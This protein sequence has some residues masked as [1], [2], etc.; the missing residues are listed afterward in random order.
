[1]ATTFLDKLI[2]PEK[3]K[4]IWAIAPSSKFLAEEMVTERDIFWAEVIVEFWAGDGVFTQRIF[5]LAERFASKNVK[6]FIIELDPELY[7]KLIQ[8]FPEHKDSIYLYDALKL[9]EL[10]ASNW[11][12]KVD[13]IISWLP[14]VSLPKRFFVE[15]MNIIWDVSHIKTV[16]KQFTYIALTQDDKERN[17]AK[18]A[19][20][21]DLVIKETEFINVP[22]AFVLTCMWFRKKVWD[23]IWIPTP[24][25]IPAWIER[26]KAG[27]EEVKSALKPMQSKT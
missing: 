24:N 6:I 25:P 8:K 22:P 27:I 21:F 12:Q 2:D 1:M 3:R 13:V 7:Q 26:I 18:Y 17:M 15:I 16:F 14:F 10:L 20:Y 11:I 23:L 5:E 9:P 19:K 4:G